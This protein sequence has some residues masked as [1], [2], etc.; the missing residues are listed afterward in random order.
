MPAMTSEQADIKKLIDALPKFDA[1]L[2]V[3]DIEDG[4]FKPVEEGLS[5]YAKLLG[6]DAL[7]AAMN[8]PLDAPI[9][10]D[11]GT[12]NTL[13]DYIREAKR[14]QLTDE[15][16]V[17]SNSNARRSQIEGIPGGAQGQGHTAQREAFIKY[18]ESRQDEAPAFFL[19][20]L[21]EQAGAKNLFAKPGNEPVGVYDVGY[22][23]GA[24]SQKIVQAIKEAGVAPENI[25]YSGADLLSEHAIAE[26]AKAQNISDARK[27]LIDE[28]IPEQ[29]IALT[30]GKLGFTDPVMDDK[31]TPNGALALEG[32][33]QQHANDIVAAINVTNFG[34]SELFKSQLDGLAKDNAIILALHDAGGEGSLVEFRKNLNALAGKRIVRNDEAATD[35]VDKMF[36]ATGEEPRKVATFTVPYTLKIPKITDDMWNAMKATK[37]GEFNTRY[38]DEFAGDAEAKK[39]YKEARLRV[40]FIMG[41]PLNT[42]NDGERALALDSLKTYLEEKQ[43]SGVYV[44]HGRHKGQIA[45]SKEHKQELGEAVDAAAQA[46][47]QHFN[48]FAS[49]A[50]NEKTQGRDGPG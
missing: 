28:G 38:E 42:F 4:K 44:I 24:Q 18:E 33:R 39:T 32:S 10:F 49:L 31:T 46:T 1:S 9:V 2:S 5:Y 8:T 26:K 3:K 17:Y 21:A 23:D 29:N 19:S 34:D 37:T 7:H 30:W 15:G 25:L 35:V 11:G 48:H 50:Q 12:A 45:L 27:R 16:Q 47:E 36:S 6:K 41:Q 13:D 20:K 22:Y 43:S 40:E 14:Y